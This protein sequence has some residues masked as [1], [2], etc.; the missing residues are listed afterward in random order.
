MGE[1]RG[2]GG[3]IANFSGVLPWIFRICDRKNK[4]KPANFTNFR[5]PM[6][7]FSEYYE[8]FKKMYFLD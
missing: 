6:P 8:K 5:R 1:I 3:I 2:K 4:I 7:L